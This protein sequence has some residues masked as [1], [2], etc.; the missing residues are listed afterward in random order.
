MAD[1]VDQDLR[2]RLGLE[3]YVALFDDGGEFDRETG[4]P[5]PQMVA[6]VASV[7][8]GAKARATAWLPDVYQGV[9][10]FTEPGNPLPEEFRELVLMYAEAYAYKR[11]PDYLKATGM[12]PSVKDLLAA[13]ETMGGN[14]QSSTLRMWDAQRPDP[15]NVGGI[16]TAGGPLFMIQSPDGTDNGSGF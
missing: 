12:G 9:L 14:I 5:T 2:N 7:I 15:G 13:A 10:P 6:A 8:A 4:T 16:V 11:N 1:V 3:T